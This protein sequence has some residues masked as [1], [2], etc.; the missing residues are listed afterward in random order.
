MLRR[1]GVS[2]PATRILRAGDAWERVADR[3]GY[4]VVIKPVRGAGCERVRLARNE[5]QLR[6][7]FT[8]RPHH[9][10]VE[11]LVLQ[12]YVPGQPASV[13]LPAT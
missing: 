11:S 8:R 10:G 4:P 7:L 2:H 9:G 6:H 3:V 12:E 5:R 1:H 13:S